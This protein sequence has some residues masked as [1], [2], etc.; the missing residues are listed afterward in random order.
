MRLDLPVGEG[1]V[2]PLAGATAS[3]RPSSAPGW[4]LPRRSS[5]SSACSVPRSFDRTTASAPSSRPWSTREW[6]GR[7]CWPSAIP[8]A[9]TVDL[10]SND[11]ALTIPAVVLPDGSG[12]LLT[13]DM[14]QL[15]ADRTYQLWGQT[16][17]GLVSLGL[18]GA[19]PQDVVAFQAGDD[20]EALAVTDEEAPGVSRSKNAPVVAGRFDSPTGGSLARARAGRCRHPRQT[21]DIPS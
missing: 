11:G 15:A 20:V 19:D 18:L 5:W 13:H 3:V 16:E 12:Y 10:R 14:A 6:P 7:R 4:P 1:S 21:S 17:G 8:T 9:R 2:V